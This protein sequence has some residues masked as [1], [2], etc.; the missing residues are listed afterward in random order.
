MPDIIQATHPDTYD[1]VLSFVGTGYVE[2]LGQ[3]DYCSQMPDQADA[4]NLFS[5][6]LR[7]SASVPPRTATCVKKLV[8]RILDADQDGLLDY[9]PRLIERLNRHHYVL[10]VHRFSP[11]VMMKESDNHYSL[12]MNL[13]NFLS[14]D[15][16][17]KIAYRIAHLVAG[18]A[19]GLHDM[20]GK[21]PSELLAESPDGF[22]NNGNCPGLEPLRAYLEQMDSVNRQYPT[23]KEI[24]DVDEAMKNRELMIDSE[25]LDRYR[26]GVCTTS[27]LSIQDFRKLTRL[28]AFHTGNSMQVLKHSGIGLEDSHPIQKNWLDISQDELDTAGNFGSIFSKAFR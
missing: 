8:N 22:E 13:D 5:F 28:F 18:E 26:F 10:R 23:A 7:L 24:K 16:Q 1:F 2:S 12:N 17:Q 6:P 19:T 4:V 9:A 15:W 3:P 25:K 27:Q 20:F 11:Y 21:V 14:S